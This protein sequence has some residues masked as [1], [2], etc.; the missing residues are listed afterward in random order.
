MDAEKVGA[1]SIFEHAI[2][3]IVHFLLFGVSA[4]VTF[5]SFGNGVTFLSWHPSLMTIGVSYSF[6][7]K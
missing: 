5:K 7:S 6:Y 3:I 1:R 2:N 4:F